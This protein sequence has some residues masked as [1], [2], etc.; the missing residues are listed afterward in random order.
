MIVGH[1]GGDVR[2]Y[3]FS[4]SQQTVHRINVD[5]TLMPYENV[6]AQVGGPV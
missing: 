3:Q 6:A 1:Q 2:L 4:D 5:E